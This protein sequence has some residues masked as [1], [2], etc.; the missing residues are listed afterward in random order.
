MSTAVKWSTDKR[1]GRNSISCPGPQAA[2][3][4][5]T[6]DGTVYGENYS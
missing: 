5:N 2:E 3:K 1:R 6:Y 4:D